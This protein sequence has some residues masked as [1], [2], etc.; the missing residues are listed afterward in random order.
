MAESVTD[1]IYGLH[2]HLFSDSLNKDS[3]RKF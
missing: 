1:H 2:S 3:L